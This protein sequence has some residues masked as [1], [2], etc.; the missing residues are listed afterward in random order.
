[1]AGMN[2]VTNNQAGTAY[3]AR[4]TEPGMEM[5]G[6]TGTS[7]VRRISMAERSTGVKKNDELPWRERDHALFVAFAP[8]QAPRYACSVIVEHGGGGSAIAAPIARDI[9]VECQKRDPGRTS[10]ADSGPPQL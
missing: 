7:Q 3:K 8:V 9:L 4:I 6:K 5:A 10:V 2:A 1:V